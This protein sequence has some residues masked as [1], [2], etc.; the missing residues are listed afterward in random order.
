MWAR[1]R[2]PGEPLR[3]VCLI[4][5]IGYGG[6]ER[7]LYLVLKHLDAALIERHVVVFN[8]HGPHDHVGALEEAGVRVWQIPPD[9]RSIPA[10]IR[11]LRRLFADVKPHVVH[12]WTAHDNPYA[13]VVGLLTRVPGRLGSVRGSWS[14]EGLEHLPLA[15]RLLALYSVPTVVVNSASIAAELGIHRCSA[16]RVVVTRNALELG[17]EPDEE[18]DR[19]TILDDLGVGRDKRFVVIIGNIRAV[20]N[21]LMFIDA[22]SAIATQ[23]PDVRGVIV[24]QRAP[25]EPDLPGLL[26]TR[27]RERGMEKK[28]LFTGFRPNVRQLLPHAAVAC[29]TSNQEGSPNVVI[30]AM[31]AGRPVAATRA[32]GVP[33]LIEDGDTGLL[34]EPGDSLGMAAALRRLLAD[35]QFARRLGEAARQSVERR[36]GAARVASRLAA[37]YWYEERR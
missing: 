16:S 24:G 12:S 29:L 1:G 3:L 10:R 5:Q 26:R 13:G 33:E 8:S 15:A 11:F 36:F 25:N 28:I 35:E 23:F 2:L 7:Q 27:V 4:G 9:C 19:E 18:I 31:A 34:V 20:K 37:L 14:A 6:S 22:M 30:E 32:G 17:Q 21:H